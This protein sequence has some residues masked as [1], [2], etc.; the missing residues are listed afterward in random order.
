MVQFD[1]LTAT[2][3]RGGRLTATGWAQ[4]QPGPPRLYATGRLE[5]INLA[6]LPGVSPRTRPVT[7]R[8]L[9]STSRVDM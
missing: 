9:V 3:V 1:R 2:T 8:P 7:T 4:V 5:N 6:G